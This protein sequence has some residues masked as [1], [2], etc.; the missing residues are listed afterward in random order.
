MKKTYLMIVA[1][2]LLAVGAYAQDDK[3]KL[4]F[5]EDAD[6]SF[7]NGVFSFEPVSYLAWGDFVP[8]G[9]EDGLNPSDRRNEFTVNILEFRIRPYATGQ[10]AIGIDYNRDMFRIKGDRLWCPDKANGS[11]SVASA[12]DFGLKSV[13]KSKLIVNSFSCPVSFGQEFGKVSLRVGA[14]A[15]YNL[16]GKTKFKGVDSSGNTIKPKGPCA[17]GRQYQDEPFHLQFLC[18][19]RLRWGG[20]VCEVCSLRAFPGWIRPAVQVLHPGCHLRPGYVTTFLTI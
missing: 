17:C 19:R 20:R 12:S 15:V 11:V 3:V 10:F 6:L 13:K 16:S 8:F 7:G 1:A 9:G 4:E 2:L 18:S 14:S 5:D